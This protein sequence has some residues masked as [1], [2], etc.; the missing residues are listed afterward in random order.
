LT[1]PL[2]E[3][4]RTSIYELTL[5]DAGFIYHLLN[6][7]GWIKYI[8]DRDVGSIVE[9]QI[10]IENSFLKAYQLGG[11][12]YYIAKLKTEIGAGKTND[13]VGIAGFLKKDYLENPDFG[14]AMS[15][16]FYQQGL[17]SEIGAAVL[18]FGQQQFDFKV[19]DA[20]TLQTNVGSQKLLERLGFV[21]Q[22]EDITGPN[23]ERLMLYRQH[24]LSDVF[25]S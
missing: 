20:V 9:A 12:G 25:L 15:P 16:K 21:H 7:P 22:N 2:T 23:N 5:E 8:G 1:T 3:T 6:S 10:F 4:I 13:A 18:E 17:G 19:L 14:F 24:F 11:Y